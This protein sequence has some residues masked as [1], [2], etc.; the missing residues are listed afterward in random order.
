[1]YNLNYVKNSVY[2]TGTTGTA[3][4][5]DKV[6]GPTLYL[7]KENYTGP[8]NTFTTSNF[9]DIT[10]ITAA[11]LYAIDGE[12][13]TFSLPAGSSYLMYFR[14]DR[15]KGTVDQETPA[16]AAATSVTLTAT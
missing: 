5:F 1:N 4:G 11:P 16:G 13:G 2:L 7:Y 12:T 9:R 14:G 8:G 15:S 3:G 6:S 10:D